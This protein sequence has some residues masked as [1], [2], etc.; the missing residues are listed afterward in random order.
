MLGPDATEADRFEFANEARARLLAARRR[1]S[2]FARGVIERELKE[3]R[4]VAAGSP[5]VY[6]TGGLF[7]RGGGGGGSP[8]E[9]SSAALGLL[10]ASQHYGVEIDPAELLTTFHNAGDWLVP[11]AEL[12][13]LFLEERGSL[14]ESFEFLAQVEGAEDRLFPGYARFAV[15][16]DERVLTERKFLRSVFEREKLR[17]LEKMVRAGRERL[18]RAAKA[19]GDHEVEV[20]AARLDDVQVAGIKLAL[21]TKRLPLTEDDL[22][23][24]RDDR[25]PWHE[26][27]SSGFSEIPLDRYFEPL[28]GGG[29]GGES[30]EL[31]RFLIAH[32]RLLKE[33]SLD[34]NDAEQVRGLVELCG[35]E[36]RV[37]ALYV[38][39]QADRQ[40]WDSRASDPG[41]WW[42]ID[43]LCGKAMNWFRPAED[44]A[45]ALT[46]AGFTREQARIIE[47]L[48]ADFHEGRYR[49]H[50]NRFGEHLVRLVEEPGAGPMVRV[51][52]D[53]A[54]TILGVAARDYR[55]LAATITGALW[56]AT[57]SLR[58][59]HLFS[60]MNYGLV[61][62]F[63]HVA[64]GRPIPAGLTR[65][66]T[67]AIRQ[68]RFIADAD[69]ARLPAVRGSHHLREWRPGQFCLRFETDQDSGGLVYAVAYRVFR[70]LRGSI[71]SLSA[72]ATRGTAYVAAYFSPPEGLTLAEAQRLVT[73]Y[74][75]G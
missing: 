71:F 40:Y 11:V 57:L 14:A 63:F 31:A 18:E 75:R 59:A 50:A 3:G 41:R 24:R 16:L 51:F 10:V 7:H 48:G 28:A 61:L 4:P 53:G 34:P 43:E 19:L 44:P 66:V 1:V 36:A 46:A 29:F 54:S 9:R 17:A 5:I 37:R 13:A 2:R 20:E 64:G 22:A 73:E 27:Y 42:A 23:A 35:S 62:D 47:D 69:E 68:Q 60:A 26:R 8:E 55:G 72:H 58:Q 15:S 52:P 25:R 70:Y 30:L 6:G 32:R 65:V 56:E 67:E 39:T 45:K 33:R 49:R 74:F 21:K 12:G 38:F